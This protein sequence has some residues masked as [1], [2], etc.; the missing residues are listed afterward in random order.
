MPRVT[1]TLQRTHMQVPTTRGYL[2]WTTGFYVFAPD[3]SRCGPPVTRLQAYATAR[4]QW[5]GCTIVITK[6]N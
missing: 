3:G 5:P 2:R 6:E 1:I 4:T